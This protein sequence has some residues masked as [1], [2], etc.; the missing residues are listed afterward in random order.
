MVNMLYRSCP[1]MVSVKT[2]NRACDTEESYRRATLDKQRIRRTV[3]S[4]VMNATAEGEESV[5][6]GSLTIAEQMEDLNHQPAGDLRI[7]VN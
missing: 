6:G 1:F 3:E 4:L 7:D 2:E 5:F